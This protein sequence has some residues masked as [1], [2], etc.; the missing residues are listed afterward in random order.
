MEHHHAGHH[1]DR[2]SLVAGHKDCELSVGRSQP[3]L[4]LQ[5]LDASSFEAA[6]VQSWVEPLILSSALVP[7]IAVR[8]SDITDTQVPIP[9]R[10]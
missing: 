10:I 8:D 5:Q 7:V 2:A 6:G 9:I 1:H 4:A 3:V